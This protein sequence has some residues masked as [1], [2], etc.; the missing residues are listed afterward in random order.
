VGVNWRTGLMRWKPHT[1]KD[2]TQY[3][4]NHLHPFR[5]DVV[6]AAKGGLPEKTINV[7]VGFGMH[8]FTK[9]VEPEDCPHDSYADDRETRTFDRLRYELSRALRMVAR[10]LPERACAFAKNENFVTVDVS[11]ESGLTH[12]YGV[13]FNMKRW[14]A[15]G[16]NAVLVTIQSAYGLDPA[17]PSPERGK[18]RFNVLLGHVMRGTRPVAPR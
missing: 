5:Y 11:T 17:K 15:Q 16:T 10:T 1:G 7:H 13:F 3:P 6:L 14:P 12:R 2:G 8:C 18:I 4:L 9:K